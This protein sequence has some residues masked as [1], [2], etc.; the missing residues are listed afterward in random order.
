[1]DGTFLRGGIFRAKKNSL[2]I[3]ELTFRGILCAKKTTDE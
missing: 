1:M 2:I 3:S